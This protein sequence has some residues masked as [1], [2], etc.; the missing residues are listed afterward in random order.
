M[1]AE[2]HAAPLRK[3]SAR[4]LRVRLEGLL[5]QLL[6]MV[7]TAVDELDALDPDSDLE[8]DPDLEPSLGSTDRGAG[9]CDQTAWGYSETGDREEVCEDEAAQCED[10]GADIGDYEPDHEHESCHWQDE[11]DQTHL[12]AHRTFSKRPADVRPS[13]ANVGELVPVS[14]R[15]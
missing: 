7:Q 8:P 1:T 6:T 14:V 2:P 12:I 3:P 10:E 11:G 5:D 9:K 15:P 13:W 4:Q